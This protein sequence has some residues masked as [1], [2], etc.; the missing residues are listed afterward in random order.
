[1]VNQNTGPRN[2]LRTDPKNVVP[3]F[4]QQNKFQESTYTL[5][6]V[7]NDPSLSSSRLNNLIDQIDGNRKIGRAHV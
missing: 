1:M 4:E 2:Q 5:E 3:P 7:R 6:I